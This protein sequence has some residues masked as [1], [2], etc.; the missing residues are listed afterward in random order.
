MTNER[1]NQMAE[2]SGKI[3]DAQYIDPEYSIIKV[4]Y[5]DNGSLTV[6]N[7]DVNPDHPDYQA[8]EEEGWDHDKIVDSTA[9]IKKAQAAAFS[10]EVNNAARALIEESM[11]REVKAL[12]QL[13]DY[14]ELFV[15]DTDKDNLF[16]FKL[17]ALENSVVQSATKD[18]KSKIRKAAS[19]LEGLSILYD[20]KNQ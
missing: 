17:W 5:D 16:K 4:L 13:E 12:E 14:F 20:I 1:N 2:F 7:V 6:Y 8:L 9:E 11:S 19:L 3:V 15:N 18:Q 10:I